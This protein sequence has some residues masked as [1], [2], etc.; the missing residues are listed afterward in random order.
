MLSA[1]CVGGSGSGGTGSA[2]ILGPSPAAEMVAERTLAKAGVA[3]AFTLEVDGLAPETWAWD[4][5]DG[6]G[7]EG[8]AVPSVSHAFAAAGTYLVTATA[9]DSSGDSV[10]AS[11]TVDV[12]PAGG[13]PVLTVESVEL[14]GTVADATSCSLTVNNTGPVA[15]DAG[16]FTWRGDLDASPADYDV[17]AVDEGGNVTTRTVT[18]TLVN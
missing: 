5:G 12:T 11:V 6:E 17:R 8:E 3:V 7:I 18:V 10:S 13:A 1:G 14:R 2:P 16:E 9:T 4:F 15:L